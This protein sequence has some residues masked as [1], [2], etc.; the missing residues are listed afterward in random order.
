MS[1]KLSVGLLPSLSARQLF[2]LALVLSALLALATLGSGFF[3][4]DYQQR[5]A[6]LTG[7]HHNVF[8]F[9]H[10]GTAT[11]EAQM[12][13]GVL[14]WW[15]HPDTKVM[16]SRPV[17]Q[18]LMQVDYRLWPN[19]V[20]LMHL[21]SALWYAV[22]ALVACLTY[23]EILPSRWAAGLAT[24]LFA[25]DPSH[26]AV[27]WL[28]NRNIM[29]C[30]SSALLSLWC[31]RRG[32]WRWQIA[33]YSLFALSLACGEA[34]L[35]IT[36]Y[37][38]AHAVFLSDE[39][40]R[41]R[42]MRLLPF[43]LIA[44]IWLAIWKSEGFGTSGPGFYINPAEE[45][46]LFLKEALYRFPAY[47]VGQF[48]LPPAEIFAG[49]EDNAARAF[50]LAYAVG[51]VAL[52]TWLF[53]PLLRHSRQAR[54]FALGLLVAAVPICSATPVIR[55]LWF[56]GFG[57]TGLLA[58]FI[59]QFRN[60][61]MSA[62]RLRLSSVFAG[63]MVVIHLWISPLLF[64]LYS[65]AGDALDGIMDSRHV[66]LPDTG[67][68]GANVLAI[69]TLSYVGSITFPLLKDAALSLGSAPARPAPSIARI[70]ALAEGE[71]EYTLLRTGPDTLV[72]SRPDGFNTLRPSPYGFAAADRVRLDDV[73]II[74][75]SV[76]PSRAPTV[77]EYDFRRG[78]LEGYEIIAWQQDHFVPAKLPA[79]GESADI[80]TDAACSWCGKRDYRAA[81]SAERKGSRDE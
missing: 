28:A 77:I 17:A 68:P 51:I 20:W 10:R 45:P 35:A 34:G 14:S 59:E 80:R 49:M 27:A 55:S 70:R 71:G 23:R 12:Q 26:S 65:K 22:T 8:E 61:P 37:Y 46:L 69:S 57:A 79:V 32:P 31:Y 2:L 72:A 75:R 54:F 7:G 73:E 16:F 67:T 50:A 5:I 39:R 66:Q 19:D 38:L 41:Q 58:L 44:L 18:W 15:T 74:V 4:D 24:V 62:R 3:L 36:G 9:F 52:L 42:V 48:F 63:T 40:W 21:H 43:A 78:A 60:L 30:L 1:A 11:G 56:V 29:P 13:Q 76:S 47:L 25:L 33:A 64:I 6:L 81:K 53:L